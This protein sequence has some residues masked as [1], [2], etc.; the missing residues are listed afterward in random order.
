[1]ALPAL[2]VSALG[3]SLLSSTLLVLSAITSI[4]LASIG[5]LAFR[6]RGSLSYFLVAAA[7]VVFALKALVGGLTVLGIVEIHLHDVI[8]HGL[9]LLMGLLLLGAIYVA[10]GDHNCRLLDRS[11]GEM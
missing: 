4:V 10:R 8:E 5:V 2:D 3:N 1:M 9:D 7:L 6:R 11:M